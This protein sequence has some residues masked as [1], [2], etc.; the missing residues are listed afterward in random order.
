MLQRKYIS[1]VESSELAMQKM[2]Y[3]QAQPQRL[4]PRSPPAQV[5]LSIPLGLAL[6]VLKV[7]INH[8]HRSF[9]RVPE[10]VRYLLGRVHRMDKLL[11]P[12][13]SKVRSPWAILGKR[14]EYTRGVGVENHLDVQCWI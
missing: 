6:A 11:L 9:G 2:C 10:S 8:L 3:D 7:T 13:L 4:L 5:F 12:R 1:F 14:M